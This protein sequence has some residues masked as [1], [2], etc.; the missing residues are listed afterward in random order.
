MEDIGA[1]FSLLFIL[2]FVAFIIWHRHRERM[3]KRRLLLDAQTRI[4][5]RIGTGEALSA[6]LQ[7]EQGQALL[8][9]HEVAEEPEKPGRGHG[10]LRMSIIG[11]LTA[12]VICIGIG[13]GF[14]YAAR[15]TEPELV[16]PG[17]IVMGVGVGCI[18][19]AL[20]HYL[21]GTVWGLLRSDGEQDRS[22]TRS[23]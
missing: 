17:G 19:A 14:Q 8:R 18:V 7:T 21:L 5:D 23:L 6:F 11:L 12:G 10:G 3:E 1:A 2:T 22:R 16:I 9:S 4:L 13:V 15:L 20:I